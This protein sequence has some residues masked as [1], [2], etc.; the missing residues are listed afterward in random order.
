MGNLSGYSRAKLLLKEDN[1]SFDSKLHVFVIKG[2]S[3]VNRVVTLFPK[4]SCSCPSTGECYH[5][6]GAKRFL[7]IPVDN[8][9]ETKQNLTQLRKNN[10]DKKEKKCGRKRPRP[11]DTDPVLIGLNIMHVCFECF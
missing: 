4:E 3:G 1:I 7:G 6:L 5:I 11:N 10:R 2:T 9:R 8:K